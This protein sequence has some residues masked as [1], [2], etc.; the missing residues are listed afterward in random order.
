M[1]ET[2]H[3]VAVERAGEQGMTLLEALIAL[4]LTVFL[5][6]VMTDLSLTSKDAQ[7]YAERMSRATE[8]NQ[9]M[10]ND[11]RTELLSSVDLILSGTVGDSYFAAIDLDPVSPP[12]DSCRLPTPITSGPFR[13]ELVSAEMTGN[14]LLFARH[15]WV[16]E[17]TTTGGN[18]Y[19][20]NVYRLVCFYMTKEDGGPQPGSPLGLNLARY[21]SEPLIDGGQID[22]I[23]D[24]TDLAEVADHLANATPDNQ[25]ETHPKAVLVWRRGDSVTTLDTLR[26]IDPGTGL[27]SS[28]PVAPRPSGP[29]KILRDEPSSAAGMLYYR[30]FSI[31]SNFAGKRFG[32]ARFGLIETSGDG[33]PHGFE[34]Q[35]NGASSA[36]Q[37]LLHSS[38]V[39]TNNN[40]T[41]A[42]SDL[43]TTVYSQDT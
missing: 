12:L 17:F 7:K 5:V 4:V 41:K 30:H 9:A 36:R 29:W 34:V 13:K 27:L 6:G 28:T 35:V 8:V 3:T 2:R 10:L 24:S 25:G 37:V 20:I 15:D 16:T 38:I 32:V 14:V 1:N 21:V 26:E 19:S 31:A 11:M 22:E 40:G 33:F 18:T 42:H 23:T 43:R 39:S